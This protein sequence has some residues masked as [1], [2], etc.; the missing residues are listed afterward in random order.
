MATYPTVPVDY[1]PAGDGHHC[2]ICGKPATT[3]LVVDR[4]TND[5]RVCAPRTMCSAKALA[6]FDLRNAQPY[7]A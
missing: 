5:V 2:I 7:Y 6:R 3:L 1:E 4:K